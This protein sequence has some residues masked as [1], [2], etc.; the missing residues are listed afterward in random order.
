MSNNHELMFTDEAISSEE[1]EFVVL[2][3]KDV[4]DFNEGSLLPLSSDDLKIVK[5]WLE[6][7]DYFA[8]SSE[9]NKHLNSHLPG[10]CDWIQESLNYKEWHDGS[11]KGC[12]WIKAVA[13]AGKSVAAASLASRLASRGTAP[14]LFFFFRQIVTAN[15]RPQSLLRDYLSQL[16]MY[17]PP[18]QHKLKTWIDDRRHLDSVSSMELW[19]ALQSS[20]VAF[21]RVYCI[22]DALDEM[23]E[24]YEDFLKNLV[25]LGQIKPASIKVLLTSRPLPR[26]EEVL[27]DR[28]VLPIIL[29]ESLVEPDIQVYIKHR[30]AS[31]D[32][33]K[34]T[35]ETAQDIVHTKSKGLFLY[36]R[37]VIDDILDPLNG[38]VKS[39]EN[40]RMALAK[41][42]NTLT[43]M[44]ARMLLEHS[45]RSG[46]KQDLQIKILRWVTR[47]ERPLRVLELV[48]VTNFSS[49][50]FFSKD[51]KAVIRRGCGPLLEILEDETVSVI[52]HSLTEFLFDSRRQHNA[53]VE[54]AGFPL[55]D[56][57]STQRAIALICITFLTKSGW[58]HDFEAPKAPRTSSLSSIGAYSNKLR[59]AKRQTK[60]KYPFLS[61]AASNWYR[62]AAK[63]DSLDKELLAALDHLILNDVV[64]E[65]WST[66]ENIKPDWKNSVDTQQ[67]RLG[68]LHV[69]ARMGISNYLIHL[70]K[71]GENVDGVGWNARTPVS[72]TCEV[73]NDT[74]QL[75]LPTEFSCSE[76]PNKAT[77]KQ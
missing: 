16:L 54:N 27:R 43:E 46:V 15:Q 64:F 40:I 34:R 11:E 8:D 61:Y 31:C 10:T 55:L 63:L 20:L 59:S 35:R 18:L 50:K 71:L 33:S 62:H 72:Q 65:A 24:G 12:L 57:S 6:P 25:A 74:V 30:L 32:M 4:E 77:R 38:Y 53:D 5:A 7:T 2:D 73:S 23:D 14:M 42:P 26:I 52:H 67:D 21:P 19:N 66:F 51:T 69:A 22:V 58:H 36:A 45:I 44:Y 47:S 75:Y 9:Y 3:R 37:L 56:D 70:I 41:T 39:D 17:S 13:G 29:Q 28:S 48:N 68:P 76:P 49:G 60:L 1:G